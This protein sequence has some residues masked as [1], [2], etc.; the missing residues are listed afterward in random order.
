MAPEYALVLRD[1]SKRYPGV[2]ALRDMHLEVRPGEVHAVVGENGSGKST[3][4]GVSSGALVPDSGSVEILGRPLREARPV[5]ARRLG[6]AQIYQDTSL[7]LELS[8][9]QNLYMS[10]PVDERPRYTEMAAWAQR[11][12]DRYEIGV[13]PQAEVGSVSLAQRQF[14]EVIKALLIH[15]G[16]LLM[17]EPTTALGPADV[18]RLHAIVRDVTAGGTAVVYVSHR[19]PEVL[20]LADRVTILRDGEH[21]GTFDPHELNEEEMITVMV[22]APVELEFPPRLTRVA[23]PDDLLLTVRGLRNESFGPIDLQVRRGEILGVA[24]AEGN[25]QRE[26]LR[27]LAGFEIATGDVT[28]AGGRARLNSPQRMLRAGVML[29]S[30]D[31]REAIFPPLGTRHNMTVQV[32]DQFGRFRLVAGRRERTV[33]QRLVDELE[34]VTPSLEQPVEFLSGGNQQK[35]VI[36]R[37]F[38]VPAQVVM[39][40]QPTQGV[41]VKARLDIYHALRAKAGEGVGVIVNSS[42]AFELAGLCDRVIVL[43]RGRIV[44]Q[45]EGDEL[46][47]ENVV[48]SFVTS[49]LQREDTD[50]TSGRPRARTVWW[51][52]L[53]TAREANWMPLLMIAILIVGMAAYTHT[54]SDAFLSDFNLQSLLF[55]TVPLAL[56]AMAQLHVMLVGGFDISVGAHMSLAVVVASFFMLRGDAFGLVVLGGLAVLGIGALAGGLN[57]GLVRFIR[58]P[59][60]IATIAT[61]SLFGGIALLLRETSGGRINT[62]FTNALR[63]DLSFVPYAFIGLVVFALAADFW[64]YRTDSGLNVR[65]VGFREEAARR[66]GIATTRTHVRAFV[67]AGV[68]AALAGLFLAAQVGVGAASIGQPFTLRSIAAAVLGGAALTGGRGSFVGAMLGALLLQ[69]TINIIPFLEINPAFGLI[70][71]GAL[72]LLAVMVYSRGG[73]WTR[74]VASLQARRRALRAEAQ[75]TG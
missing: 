57:A 23:D 55:A 68:F 20:A 50:A 42:D 56:V 8:V 45:L 63:G 30:G 26:L 37:S 67:L 16:V 33:A 32:L 11:I 4:L 36:A 73:A 62:S 2:Q 75:T 14:L 39:I 66:I 43:S 41:D 25:G 29:L 1:I 54:E 58:M 69:L 71:A 47:E 3:L 31:R 46:T 65:A 72:T 60:V 38:L 21:Q 13:S 34:I 48:A 5:A 44:R 10:A 27:A 70:M 53:R 49:R 35:T 28:V 7:T 9:A 15:P 24:G 17:D 61:F 22:G 52:R 59:S 64:L 40:D 18:E 51:G 19:L 74:L 6:L 12:L